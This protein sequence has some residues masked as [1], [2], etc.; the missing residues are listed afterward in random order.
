MGAREQAYAF[1]RVALLIQHAMRIRH[2][3]CF[4]SGSTIFIGII[5][6]AAQFSEKRS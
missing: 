3:V 2:I 4:L 6:K 5:S 1:A